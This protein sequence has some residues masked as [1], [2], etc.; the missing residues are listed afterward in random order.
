MD[1]LTDRKTEEIIRY[2]AGVRLLCGVEDTTETIDHTSIEVFRNMIGPEGAEK[3]NKI[4]VQHAVKEG[5][6]GSK[7]CSSDTTVQEAPINHPTEVGHLRKIGEELTGIGKR[8]KKGVSLKLEKLK[9]K[10]EKIVT[11]VRL[12]T[13]GKG[14]KVIEEKKKLGKKLHKTVKEMYQVV[15]KSLG[16][17]SSAASEQYKEDMVLYQKMLQQIEK[18]MKTGFHPA[19]KI[20]SLW[21]TEARAITRGKASRAVVFH[22]PAHL[23]TPMVL[24]PPT[25]FAHR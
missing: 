5:F 21:Y 2:H 14:K 13:R 1:G 23:W 16:K 12:F 22:L 18:W 20:I 7:L 10:A 19:G 3:L 4:I 8:I 24:T 15:E 17:M 11:E 6:T 25:R 9:E